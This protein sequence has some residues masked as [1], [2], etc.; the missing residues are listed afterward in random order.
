M[1]A[2]VNINWGEKSTSPHQLSLVLSINNKKEHGMM[3][4]KYTVSMCLI[5]D[6]RIEIDRSR[7]SLVLKNNKNKVGALKM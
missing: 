5:R 4:L 1:S 2:A 6:S 3:K 7:S